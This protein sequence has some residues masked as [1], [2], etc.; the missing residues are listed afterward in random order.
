MGSIDGPVSICPEHGE[1]NLHTGCL[2][3]ERPERCRRNDP[4]SI[5]DVM[6]TD[7][8]ILCDCP[9]CSFRVRMRTGGHSRFG[10]AN[11]D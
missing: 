4:P 10:I 2:R 11:N 6:M 9:E 8:K 7:E 3:C 1:Y 5:Y